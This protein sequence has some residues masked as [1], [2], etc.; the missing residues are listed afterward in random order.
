MI[1]GFIKPV[2]S[3]LK[4][5]WDGVWKVVFEFIFFTFSALDLIDIDFLIRT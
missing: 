4:G 5:S 3:F 1:F 2:C